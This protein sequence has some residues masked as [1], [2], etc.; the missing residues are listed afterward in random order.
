MAVAVGDLYEVRPTTYRP[1]AAQLGLNVLH[2]RCTAVVG[3]ISEN[4]LAQYCATTMGPLYAAVMSNQASFRGVS[5]RRLLPGTP[6]SYFTSHEGFAV[7]SVTGDGL[8]PGVAGLIGL[9]TL[10]AWRGGHGRVYLPFPSESDSNG[11]GRPTDPYIA[12]A[13]NIAAI[14]RSAWTPDKVPGVPGEVTLHAV[15]LRSA[16]PAGLLTTDAVV[17]NRWATQRRR[18]DF[19]RQNPEPVL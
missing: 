1:A 16:F 6:T 18:S 4:S 3:T 19:G 15:V 11:L 7:G 9:K 10:E 14:L 17:R 8:P 13:D 12:A 2:F 5:L